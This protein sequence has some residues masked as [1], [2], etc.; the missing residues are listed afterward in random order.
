MSSSYKVANVYTEMSLKTNKES[1]HN[2]QNQVGG[3]IN[4]LKQGVAGIGGPLVASLGALTGAIASVVGFIN[5]KSKDFKNKF[6]QDTS[7]IADMLDKAEGLGVTLGEYQKLKV[8]AQLKGMDFKQLEQT[9][10]QLNLLS[11]KVQELGEDADEQT[12]IFAKYMNGDGSQYTNFQR[13]E[14]LLRGAFRTRKEKGQE[15]A[16]R[17]LKILMPRVANNPGS[18]AAL[19]SDVGELYEADKIK[20]NNEGKTKKAVAKG[21]KKIALAEHETEYN[22]ISAYNLLIEENIK[23]FSARHEL[24]EKEIARQRAKLIKTES[25]ISKGGGIIEGIYKLKD[26]LNEILGSHKKSND[27]LEQLVAEEK[28]K[29]VKAKKHHELMRRNMG[30]GVMNYTKLK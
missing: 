24:E 16:L 18:A 5:S 17:E 14:L 1:I 9:M 29:A 20:V 15:K 10:L 21:R 3:A 7:M 28:E 30:G 4:T 19:T 8:F 25:L 12:R 11:A 23:N 27:Y 22:T 2:F 13:L 6:E 26:K